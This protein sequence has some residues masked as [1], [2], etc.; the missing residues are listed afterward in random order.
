MEEEN[1][2]T[3]NFEPL[4]WYRART[5]EQMRNDLIKQSNG[6][7]FQDDINYIFLAS[8]KLTIRSGEELND[9]TPEGPGVKEFQMMD[10]DEVVKNYIER[11]KKYP[12]LVSI[13]N[14]KQFFDTF[15]GRL[16]QLSNVAMSFKGK[17]LIYEEDGQVVAGQIQ[18]GSIGEAETTEEFWNWYLRNAVEIQ[19]VLKPGETQAE[20][21]SIVNEDFYENK[22]ME[23]VTYTLEDVIE[24]LNGSGYVD[25]S[26]IE[27]IVPIIAY[28]SRVNG[29]PFTQDAKDPT[30]DSWGIYQTNINTEMSSI[31]KVM[32]ESGIEIPG[33]TETQITQLE[34]N[35]VPEGKKDVRKF[36]EKQK[37]VVRDFLKNADLKT[38][39]KIFDD[40]YKVKAK[41]IKTDKLEDVMKELYLNTTKKFYIDNQPEAVKFKDIMDREVKLYTKKKIENAYSK[42]N[43]PTIVEA[44]VVEAPVVEAPV[45]VASRDGDM[46]LN[47]RLV[48]V[49]ASMSKAKANAMRNGIVAE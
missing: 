23:V 16:D 25:E 45:S 6:D 36:T 33:L 27:Y 12:P 46:E 42:G 11:V 37:V 10:D 8:G 18:E 30:S 2:T 35:I 29:V 9:Q 32:K 13:T 31:Y 7:Y 1:N 41:Q 26:V 15:L 4:D 14:K 24:A 20:D 47:N 5:V 19:A 38:Q 49:Y 39:T 17:D 21:Y 40:M 22:T 44:P 48:N 34:T 28:E 43:E 3:L